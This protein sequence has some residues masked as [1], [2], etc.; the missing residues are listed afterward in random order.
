MLKCGHIEHWSV[1]RNAQSFTMCAQQRQ[2]FL[3]FSSLK[4]Y[5]PFYNKLPLMCLSAIVAISWFSVCSV[6]NKQLRLFLVFLYS[7]ISI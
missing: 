6:Y 2:I 3:P 4:K 5:R 7:W 1:D